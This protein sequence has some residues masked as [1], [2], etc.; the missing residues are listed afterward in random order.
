M[1]DSPAEPAVVKTVEH[2]EAS[3]LPETNWLWRRV[4]TFALTAAMLLYAWRLSERVTDIA[5]LRMALRYAFALL[6]L[7]ALLYLAGAST[8]A[9]TRL[10]AAVKT[11]R[12]ETVTSAPPPAT[13]TTTSDGATTVTAATPE[14]DGLL[15]AGER[16][17]P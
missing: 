17:R 8:E 4:F 7:L 16:V 2:G 15:P 13:L 10:L 9:I 11:T 3:D 5:T 14:D 6:A 1:S 12:K